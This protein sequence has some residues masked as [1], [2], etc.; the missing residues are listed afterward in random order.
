MN[1]FAAPLIDC[2]FICKQKANDQFH[3]NCH[4][5][6]CHLIGQC[7]ETDLQLSAFQNLQFS[8]FCQFFRQTCQY[9]NMKLEKF[10]ATKQ[11][12]PVS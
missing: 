4:S 8:T 9:S 11:P 7:E 1:L 5:V 6:N 10:P 2:K 12:Q 3:K